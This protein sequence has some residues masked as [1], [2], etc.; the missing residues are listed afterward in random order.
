M[1]RPYLSMPSPSLCLPL[2]HGSSQRALAL[3]TKT[4]NFLLALVR[5]LPACNR[6]Q[7]VVDLKVLNSRIRHDEVLDVSTIP[8]PAPGDA[9]TYNLYP[10][11]HSP[12]TPQLFNSLPLKSH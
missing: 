3:S 10:R 8:S 7:S 5:D 6:G 9:R 1:S 2:R 4:T 12:T 11:I